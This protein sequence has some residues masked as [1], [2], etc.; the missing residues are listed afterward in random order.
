MENEVKT[1]EQ[2]STSTDAA[3]ASENNGFDPAIVEILEKI[4]EILSE[5]EKLKSDNENYK[6]GMLSYK[7]QLKKLKDDGYDIEDEDEKVSVENIAAKVLEQIKP[8]IQPQQAVQSDLAKQVSELA[9]A[10]KNKSQV[11]VSTAAG[12]GN[13]E[14]GEQPKRE[15]FSEQQLSDLKKRG[16]DP[17]KVKEN[18]L[19]YKEKTTI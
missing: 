12:G 17:E 4:P 18:I 14:T 11:T 8:L 19:R 6:T 9:I 1:E 15:F 16:L 5:N 2:A 13:V 7:N 3:K 10:L